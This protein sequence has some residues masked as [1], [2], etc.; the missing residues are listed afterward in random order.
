[1]SNATVI[2]VG[3]RFEKVPSAA[4]AQLDRYVFAQIQKRARA[5]RPLDETPGAERRLAPRVDIPESEQLVV[6]LLPS[7]PIGALA[8]RQ[9]QPPPPSFRIHDISTTGLCFVASDPAVAQPKQLIR[10]RLKGKDLDVELQAKVIY[11][12]AA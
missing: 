3:V 11:V 6:L 5:R 9:A 12:R 1:L 4:R 2:R 10:L 7:V 8:A